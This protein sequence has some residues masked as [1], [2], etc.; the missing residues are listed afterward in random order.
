MAVSR[1]EKCHPGALGCHAI[2]FYPVTN[3]KRLSRRNPH[4][5]EDQLQPMRIRLESLHFGVLRGNHHFEKVFDSQPP[6]FRGWTKVRKNS[7]AQAAIGHLLQSFPDSHV[8]RSRQKIQ[9]FPLS[10]SGRRSPEQIPATISLTRSHARS[11]IRRIPSQPA[12]PL[13]ALRRHA[14]TRSQPGA[15]AKP[16][17]GVAN[18]LAKKWSC[19]ARFSPRR[20]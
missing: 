2:D 8:A 14:D 18:S 9:G 16:P 15:R 11:A 13:T 6:Q 20:R 10:S 17:A 5:F 12:V 1:C 3:L 7:Q 19:M 4:S